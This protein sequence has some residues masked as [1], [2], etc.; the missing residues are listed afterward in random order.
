MTKKRKENK[1]EGLGDSI[2]KFTQ[3]TGIDKLV[4]FVAGEDCGCDTRR[5]WL[6]EKFKYKRNTPSCLLEKEYDWL[7]QYFDDPK[8]F[9]YVVVKTQ[10]GTIHARVF[11]HH[12]K[13]ICSCKSSPLDRYIGELR[14]IFEKKKKKPE[15]HD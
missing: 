6:N 12:Y 9:S 2:E 7:K 10:I 11:G 15:S 5:D 4:K 1:S 3:K 8:Q 13:K 14:V